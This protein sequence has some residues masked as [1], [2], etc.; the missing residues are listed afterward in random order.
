MKQDITIGTPVQFDS[1]EGPQRGR[2][3][4]LK[5]DLSNGQR[6]ALVDVP[7]TMNG[8]PWEIPVNDLKQAA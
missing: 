5:S 8:R 2:I 7:G 6:I 4:E 3:A 1:D